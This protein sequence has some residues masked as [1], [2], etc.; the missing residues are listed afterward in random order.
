MVETLPANHRDPFDRI[1]VTAGGPAIPQPYIEQLADP[2]LLVIPVG[3]ERRSQ[4]LVVLRKR[5]GKMA[6]KSLGDVAFV[7]LVGQH[8]W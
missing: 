4:Q 7:D 5:D 6:R 3:P 8:G 1:L 2:G